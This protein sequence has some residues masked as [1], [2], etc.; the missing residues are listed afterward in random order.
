M[1]AGGSMR[2][3][4]SFWRNI[5]YAEAD[6]P[7]RDEDIDSR[8]DVPVMPSTPSATDPR[9]YYEVLS[10]LWAAACSARGTDLRGQSLVNLEILNPVPD[11]FVAELG[12]KLRPPGIEHGLGRA[13]S[14]KCTRVQSQELVP[15]PAHRPSL[16]LQMPSGARILDPVPEGRHH[17]NMVVERWRENKTAAKHPAGIFMLDLRPKLPRSQVR[18]EPCG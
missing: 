10:T 16:P 5:G 2:Q 17:G 1:A 6:V 14:G 12:S 15:D 3:S 11:G 9:S 13:G 7:A 8:V 18:M 4:A